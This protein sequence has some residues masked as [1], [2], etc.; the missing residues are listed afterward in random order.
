MWLTKILKTTV[1]SVIASIAQPS[2]AEAR[3]D[4]RP[5]SPEGFGYKTSWFAVRTGEPKRVAQTLGLTDLV[6]AN[7]ASG[8]AAAYSSN[9][10]PDGEEYVFISPPAEGWVLVVGWAMPYPDRRLQGRNADIDSRFNAMFGALVK[11]FDEVQFF[12]SHRVVGFEAWA[13]ARGGRTERI[14]CYADGEVYENLGPQSLVEKQL[15]FP[16]LSGLTPEAATSAIFSIARKSDA[17]EQHLTA[18]GLSLN[19]AKR[20]ISERQRDPIPAEDDVMAIAGHWSI[21]PTRI[22]ALKLRPG[23]GYVAVLPSRMKQ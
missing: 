22:E 23:V 3:F 18:S 13:R 20:K 5:D 12:G 21:D 15:K 16:N 17:E 19:E 6:R 14:F 11:R 10:K 4:E 1:V 7:W 8:I 2:L 9:K